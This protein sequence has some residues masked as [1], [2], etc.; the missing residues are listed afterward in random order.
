MDPSEPTS[1]NTI[2]KA[3]YWSFTW[4]NYGTHDITQ[5]TQYFEK[6]KCVYKFAEEIAPTTGTEHLQGAVEFVDCKTFEFLHK[7]FPKVHW[8]QTRNKFAARQYCSKGKIHTNIEEEKEE[9][10]LEEQ[11]D[12]FMEKEYENITWKPWQEKVLNII[13]GPV[14]RRKI[15]WFWEPT[16]NCGKS[17]LTKYI[18]WRFP[19]V[20]VNGKQNDIFNGV[21]SFIGLNNKYPNPVIID[22]PRVNES[23]VCYG[24]MEKIK[25]GLFY[26]GKYEGGVVR[27]LPC[28][29]IVFANFPPDTGKMSQDRWDIYE[30]YND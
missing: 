5:L 27:L 13:K 17:F 10:T 19:T 23:Y 2:K 29:L 30:I 1:R 8:E 14:D 12:S 28:H 15:H 21:K 11:Y 24:T 7:K 26:S 16:G 25:D 18:E 3:R 9:L 4:N 22:I 6:T 20:I